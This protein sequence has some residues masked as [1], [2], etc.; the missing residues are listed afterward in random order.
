MLESVL[1]TLLFDP[2]CAIKQWQ[3]GVG[4]EKEKVTEITR[5]G[6]SSTVVTP[7]SFRKISGFTES[8]TYI[9]QS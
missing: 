1:L 9:K 5:V 2:L 3:Q 6:T 8:P 7:N 4:R